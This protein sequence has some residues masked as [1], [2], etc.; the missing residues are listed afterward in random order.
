MRSCPKGAPPSYL[1]LQDTT[2]NQHLNLNLTCPSPSVN[3]SQPSPSKIPAPK[4]RATPLLF[5]HGYTA[6]RGS[7]AGPVPG[8]RKGRTSSYPGLAE[9]GLPPATSPPSVI[10]V[11]GLDPRDV[12]GI[13]C[14]VSTARKTL[15]STRT[16]EFSHGADAPWL[17]SCDRH[18]ND[19]GEDAASRFI[20]GMHSCPKGAPP[21]YPPPKNRPQNQ[22][23]TPISPAHPVADPLPIPP[24]KSPPPK[25]VPYFSRSAE[26]TL[27]AVAARRGRCRV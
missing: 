21:S 6:S 15:S 4:T 16:E 9:N 3:P 2:K 25:P 24:P 5:R 14:A 22:H 11:L 19:G 23:P 1:P 10:P 20:A 12:T 27:P 17:D 7:E 26:D 8:L 13:Q 18:R